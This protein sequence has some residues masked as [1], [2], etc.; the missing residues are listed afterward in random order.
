MENLTKE[1]SNLMAEME[2]IVNADL[3]WVMQFYTRNYI[4]YHKHLLNYRY[5]DVIYNNIKY[6]KLTPT[7]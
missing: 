3:P 7:K 5:S 1:K 2:T 6:L 4:L